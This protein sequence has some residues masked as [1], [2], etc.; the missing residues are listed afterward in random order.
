MFTSFLIKINNFSLVILSSDTTLRG[1]TYLYMEYLDHIFTTT[2]KFEYANLSFQVF[3][4]FW[5]LLEILFPNHLNSYFC[6]AILPKSIKI[7]LYNNKIA[8]IHLSILNTLHQKNPSQSLSP[9]ATHNLH[10]VQDLEDRLA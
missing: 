3:S 10:S 1:H 8:S 4:N 7:K 6:V 2:K 9:N 5:I